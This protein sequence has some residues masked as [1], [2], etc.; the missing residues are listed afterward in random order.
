M[1]SMLVR[2]KTLWEGT[3][4]RD[5]YGVRCDQAGTIQNNNL[6]VSVDLIP[7]FHLKVSTKCTMPCTSLNK[8]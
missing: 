7:R 5:D 8:Y 1:K 3:Q 2:T 4:F 6:W